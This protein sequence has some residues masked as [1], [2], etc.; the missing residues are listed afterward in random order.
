M[1]NDDSLKNTYKSSR[2]IRRTKKV[3]KSKST[4]DW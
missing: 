2:R 1:L 4:M 3:C